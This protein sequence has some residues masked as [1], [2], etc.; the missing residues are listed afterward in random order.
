MGKITHFFPHVNAAVIALK[1]P[2]KVG[3]QIR[4]KGHTTDLTENVS[5]MQIDHKPINEA[6]K[7]DEIGL[8]VT[9][10]VRAGDTV[11]K[12]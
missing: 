3:D 11:Y 5:S 7:G 9:S 4:V 1:A 2:L 10:R 8:L 12:A 6:K